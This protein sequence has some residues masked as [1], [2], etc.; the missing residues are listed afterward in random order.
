MKL[1]FLLNF[2]VVFCKDFFNNVYSLVSSFGLEFSIRILQIC[3]RR[4]AAVTNRSRNNVLA[5]AAEAE[6]FGAAPLAVVVGG[7]L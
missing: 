5:H 1:H 4:R 7:D 6:A 3:R 2:M